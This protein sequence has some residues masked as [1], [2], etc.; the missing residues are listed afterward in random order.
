MHI[1]NDEYNAIRESVLV[2]TWRVLD[3][4]FISYYVLFITWY[5]FTPIYTL[6]LKANIFIYKLSMTNRSND[7]W[8]RN[9]QCL[10]VRLMSFIHFNR[11]NIIKFILNNVSITYT[12]IM[13]TGDIEGMNINYRRFWVKLTQFKII[14]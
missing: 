11:I 4:I 1:Q 5:V 13:M 10:F 7:K 2:K 8:W 3:V 12:V 6:A 14:D 9:W